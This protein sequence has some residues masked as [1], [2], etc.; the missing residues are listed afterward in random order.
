MKLINQY[1]LDDA[2][3]EILICIKSRIRGVD[4]KISKCEKSGFNADTLYREAAI[5]SYLLRAF[6]DMEHF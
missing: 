6:E 2:Y 3:Y 5:L 1:L 4:R